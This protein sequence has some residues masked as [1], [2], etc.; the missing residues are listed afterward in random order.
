M[1]YN[2]YMII[3]NSKIQFPMIIVGIIAVLGL[4]AF[5]HMT[6]DTAINDLIN[7]IEE[8]KDCDCECDC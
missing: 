7:S 2:I 1:V 8:E 3:L 6:A 5:A 4:M